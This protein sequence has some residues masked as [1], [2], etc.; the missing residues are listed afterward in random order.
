MRLLVLAALG[1]AACGSNVRRLDEEFRD[2]TALRRAERFDLALPKTDAGLGRAEKS[3]DLRAVWRFRLLK[4][5][6]LLGYR[7]VA[8][9]ASLLK[10]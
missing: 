10:V 5:D 6:I 4:V 2:A 8:Q 3:G 7:E 9:A 1:L